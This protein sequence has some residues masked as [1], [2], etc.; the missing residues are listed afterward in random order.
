MN[1]FNRLIQKDY[2][3]YMGG[4]ISHVFLRVFYRLIKLYYHCD[5]PYS[6][7]LNGVYF[8]HGGFGIVINPNAKIGEGTY[9]QHCVTIGS[10]DDI[11]NPKAPTIGMN[12]YIGQKQLSSEISPL[13]I[14]LR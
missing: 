9:I 2:T 8:C 4:V 10:R 3:L 14:M 11:K 12:C 13:E 1:R 7:N 6:L 5:I